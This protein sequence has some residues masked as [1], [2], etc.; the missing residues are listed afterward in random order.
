EIDGDRVLR[1]RREDDDLVAALVSIPK[2]RRVQAIHGHIGRDTPSLFAAMEAA[3]ETIDLS[4]ALADVFSGDIDFNNDVQP[5]DQFTLL[6]EKQYR[7]T[8][9]AA[10]A[11]YGPI[12]AA[13]FDND[14]QRVRA[15]RFTPPGGTPGYYDEH[16]VSMR[17]FFLRSPLKF[18]PVV[19]SPFSRSRFHPILH[20]Y[21]AH[22]G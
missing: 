17:R 1:V 2:T 5:G 7:A 16:G 6:V 18:Q 21:R 10:F 13:Q 22:L 8:G 11:G 14:G 12:L 3:G 20:K 4:I 9:D 19:T 15:V